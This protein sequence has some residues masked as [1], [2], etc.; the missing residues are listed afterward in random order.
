MK[1]IIV[2][3]SLPDG[4]DRLLSAA[5]SEGVRNMD[6]L[7][8][9]WASGEQRFDRNGAALFAAL[10]G[11]ELVAVGGVTPQTG[12]AEPAMRMRRFY[13]HPAHRRA[14][15]GRALARAAMRR[16][17]E[18]APLLTCNAR[19]TALAAPFWE[20]LGFEPVRM[21]DITHICRRR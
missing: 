6:L 12:L 4:M 20:S 21:P 2:S 10:E 17:F 15:H 16:G 14:G 3:G 19:A 5:R 1:I 13:V 11:E 9:Q 8:A 7:Q 18:Q